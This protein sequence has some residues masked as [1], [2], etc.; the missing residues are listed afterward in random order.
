MRYCLTIPELF[1]RS[2]KTE[3]AEAALEYM[4]DTVLGARALLHILHPLLQRHHN[5]Y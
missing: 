5:I 4:L 1:V 2:V 3:A